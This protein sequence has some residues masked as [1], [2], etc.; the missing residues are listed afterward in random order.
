V[1]ADGTTT[2]TVQLGYV[3]VVPA[4]QAIVVQL[5]YVPVIPVGQAIAVQ[6][7]YVPVVPAGQAIAV[8]LGYAPV[9]PVGQA[10]AMPD[11]LPAPSVGVAPPHAEKRNKDNKIEIKENG[12]RLLFT[13]PR[14]LRAIFRYFFILSPIKGFSQTP[15]EQ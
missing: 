10:I 9:V 3:P 5:G 15:K 6:L 8:Q 7:G 1:G 4:G 12:R 14:K 2:F 13:P 11:A